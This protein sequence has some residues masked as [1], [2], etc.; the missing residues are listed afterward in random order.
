MLVAVLAF[1]GIFL[2]A[3]LT[4]YKLGYIGRLSCSVGECEAVNTSKWA[5]LLGLPLAAWG[6]G[7]YV[8]LFAVAMLGVTDR[9]SDAAW[10]SKGLVA[11]TVWGVI[12]SAWLTYLELFVIRAIC[13][14]CVTSAIVVTAAFVLSWLDWRDQ[15]AGA[16]TAAE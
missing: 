13:I 2:A 3:Y 9:F 11:L 1:A 6:V 15:S 12:F 4:L 7:F 5:N 14:W 8:V 10:V 16:L